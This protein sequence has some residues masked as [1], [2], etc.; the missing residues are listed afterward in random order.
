MLHYL[1]THT[2]IL[3]LVQSLW[4]DEAFSILAAKESISFIIT[5]LGF[6]PP[7]YYTMLHFWMRVFGEGEIAARALSI[8]G[9]LLATVIIIEWAADMYKKHW[10]SWYLPLF[11]FLNPMLLYYAFEIRTYGWYMFFAT[12]A[13]YTYVKQRWGWFAVS[14]ILGFYTHVYILPFIGVLFLHW[15]WT[16][17]THSTSLLKHPWKN[18]AF[19]AFIMFGAAITPWLIK[20]IKIANRMKGSW[21]FPPDW[22]LV[23]S[24]LG[25]MFLGYEGTPWYG[26]KYTAYLSLVLIGLCFLALGRKTD[27]KLTVLFLLFG[28]APLAAVIGISFITPLFVNRYLIPTT[29]AEVLLVSTAIAA[30]R[31]AVLQKTVALVFLIGVLWFNWWYAPFHTKPPIRD[32]MSQVHM[33]LQPTDVILADNAI[34]YLET[35]Y[36]AK[37][38]SKV[39]LYNPSNNAFPWYIGDALITPSRMTRNYPDYPRRAMLVH[40]DGS[41]DIVYRSPL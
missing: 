38:R 13:L 5:R 29:I 24:V 1:L 23:K 9:F 22:Q 21:Y 19:S 14:A 17:N 40:P 3:Y 8:V 36:Y 12:A 26:W 25:N 31:H 32:T 7:L 10:L 30:I 16:H 6:E 35:L 2:P 11:F 41:F 27:K 34:I 28:I 4:R 37:D 18:P 33:V 39:Y 15:A 20:I